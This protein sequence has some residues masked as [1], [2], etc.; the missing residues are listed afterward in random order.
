MSERILNRICWIFGLAAISCSAY[1]LLNIALTRDFN[2]DE[3][4]V[5]FE[6]Y[7]LRRG[8]VLYGHDLSIHLPLLNILLVSLRSIVPENLQWI[9]A[10]RLLTVILTFSTAAMVYAT[11]RALPL[12]KNSGL[13][14]AGVFLTYGVT[15]SKGIEVRHDVLGTFFLTLSTVLFLRGTHPKRNF[16]L[17]GLGTAGIGLAVSVT[18]KA[19]IHGTLL[20]VTLVGILVSRVQERKETYITTLVAIIVPLL[21]FLGVL[22]LYL[23]SVPDDVESLVRQTVGIVRGYLGGSPS[24]S[25]SLPF[26]YPKGSYYSRILL[27]SPSGYFAGILGFF[28]FIHIKKDL[29]RTAMI[30]LLWALG[31]VLFFLTM[32]RPFPQSLLPALPALAISAGVF[33]ESISLLASKAKRRWVPNIVIFVSVLLL[34]VLPFAQLTRVYRNH[35]TME[36]QLNTIA[37]SLRNLRPGDKVMSFTKHQVFFDP[38][39]KRSRD[40]CADLFL[41]IEKE[42]FVERMIESQCK[43]VIYDYRTSLL[44]TSIREWIKRNFLPVKN[45]Y[46]MCP[47]FVVGEGEEIQPFVTIPGY[48][49]ISGPGLIMNG[50]EV[51]EGIVEL[52]VGAV[53]L[54]NRGKHS[55]FLVYNYKKSLDI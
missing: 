3:F 15:W 17:I 25:F 42:C 13:I 39:F 50:E 16:G 46:A 30:P 9:I 33:N 40:E 38:V 45:T 36:R 20:L 21:S 18:Q 53:L 37:F 11:A 41:R 23:L 54:R 35:P 22:F 55:I 6:S 26:P 8:K 10:S 51:K 12:S 34:V 49:D 19:A 14:A 43:L 52:P 2:F 32:K 44:S 28:A 48:Y 24:S 31:G 1:Y 4:Q 29:Y 7:A 27:Q 5:L 47:G